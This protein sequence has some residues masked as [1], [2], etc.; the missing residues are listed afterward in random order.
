MGGDAVW[1]W[2]GNH[3]HSREI[4]VTD[5]GMLCLTQRIVLAGVGS[6]LDL[7]IREGEFLCIHVSF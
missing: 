6:P 2:A 1:A 5:Q 7:V 4:I 3:A